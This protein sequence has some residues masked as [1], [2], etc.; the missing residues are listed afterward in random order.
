[1]ADSAASAATEADDE[2]WATAR[3]IIAEQGLNA[4]MYTVRLAARFEEEGAIEG[5]VKL[6]HVLDA[7]TEIRRRTGVRP[8]R[9]VR[10]RGT[11]A[12]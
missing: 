7:I 10:F 5:A 9:V 2:P 4:E 3:F 12:P 8:P 1:M 6:S 11:G